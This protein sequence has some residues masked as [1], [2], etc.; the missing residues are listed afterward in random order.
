[1]SQ[2][3]DRRPLIRPEVRSDHDAVREITAAAFASSAYGHNGEADLVDRLRENCDDLISLVAVLDEAVVGH[4]LFS[5][6]TIDAAQASCSGFGLAPVSVH[7]AHQRTGIGSD[8][9]NDGLKQLRLRRCPFVVLIGSPDYYQRFGF[10]VAGDCQLRHD[11]DGIRQE[12][13]MVNWLDPGRESSGT[14]RYRKEF[15]S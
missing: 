13:L 6:L 4:V 2:N 8:L 5:P 15:Y 3:R 10:Q 7:P 12:F 14:V 11:F 1:M 9:I